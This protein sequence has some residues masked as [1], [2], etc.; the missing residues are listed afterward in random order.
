MLHTAISATVTPSFMGEERKKAVNT[1]IKERERR[2]KKRKERKKERKSN[3]LY[4]KFSI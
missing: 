4:Q 2:K 3:K 1:S